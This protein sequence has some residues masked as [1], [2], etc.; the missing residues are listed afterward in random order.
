MDLCHQ[1]LADD[2]ELRLEEVQAERSGLGVDHF[3]GGFEPRIFVHGVASGV[4][5]ITASRMDCWRLS[6]LRNDW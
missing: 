3:D 2:L 5:P 6:P 4:V 1:L